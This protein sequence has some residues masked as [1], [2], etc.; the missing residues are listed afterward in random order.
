MEAHRIVADVTALLRSSGYVA[1]GPLRDA[2]RA[3]PPMILVAD[4]GRGAVD[5][6]VELLRSDGYDALG[7]DGYA[8]AVAAARAR[9]FDLLLT[10][11]DLIG[12][13]GCGL[14]AELRGRHDIDGLAVGARGTA[15]EV[16]RARG[17]GFLFL[18][19][20]PLTL[21]RVRHAVESAMARRR[22]RRAGPA[23][24][25][26]PAVGPVPVPLPR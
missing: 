8:A 20:G 23:A 4:D 7:A 17:A 12:G 9:P 1:P 5:A 25:A 21:P 2:P 13:S 14:L 10:N 24:P 19:T 3:T 11:L 16:R 15:E 26:A 18:L 22:L 6:G